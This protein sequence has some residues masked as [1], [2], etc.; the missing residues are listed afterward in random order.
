MQ[1]GSKDKLLQERRKGSLADS[2]KQEDRKETPE[3]K[4]VQKHKLSRYINSK[5]QDSV[6]KD[7]FKSR[8]NLLGLYRVLHPEDALATE[9]DM[10]LIT[11]KNVI[12]NGV[13]NDVAF[14]VKGRLM[15]LMEHQSSINWNM[16]WGI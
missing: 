14:Q 2:E 9:K 1:I 13:Y 16:P 12:S 8:E 15:V 3:H 5:Y 4:S 10:E 6:F 7:L 11:I